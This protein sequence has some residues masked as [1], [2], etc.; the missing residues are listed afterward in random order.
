MQQ[1]YKFDFRALKIAN[2]I[3]GF[4]PTSVTCKPGNMEQPKIL[5][6]T[7]EC[8]LQHPSDN[9]RSEYC[10]SKLAM[11]S[12]HNERTTLSATLHPP[13]HQLFWI[14]VNSVQFNDSLIIPE[15]KLYPYIIPLSFKVTVK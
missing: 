4:N 10:P 15:W 11:S 9:L 13:M 14:R 5:D 1:V 2:I 3:E 12:Q 6:V 8:I 7:A